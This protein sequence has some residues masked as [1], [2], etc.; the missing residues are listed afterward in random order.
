MIKW[1]VA[2]NNDSLVKRMTY[3]KKYAD[4]IKEGKI[5]PDSDLPDVNNHIHTSYSF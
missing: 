3:L 2:L 5:V 4:L 1:D